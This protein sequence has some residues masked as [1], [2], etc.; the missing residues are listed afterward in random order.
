MSIAYYK[1]KTITRFVFIE[2]RVSVRRLAS[3][4]ITHLSFRAVFV[5]CRVEKVEKEKNG[6]TFQYYSLN[7]GISDLA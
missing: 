1:L 3:I 5:A 2:P 4:H 7:I 6:A